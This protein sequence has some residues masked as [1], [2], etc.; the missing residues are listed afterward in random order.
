[1][2]SYG[3]RKVGSL[4]ERVGLRVAESIKS[5]NIPYNTPS[6]LKIR[7]LT[8]PKTSFDA[9]FGPVVTLVN[10]LFTPRPVSSCIFFCFGFMK[11]NMSSPPNKLELSNDGASRCGAAN[12]GCEFTL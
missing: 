1:M 5:A 6:I 12:M 11:S 4:S 2:S 9:T 10:P 3:S 7:K 8:P